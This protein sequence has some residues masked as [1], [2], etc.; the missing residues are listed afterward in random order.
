VNTEQKLK[1]E[2][3]TVITDNLLI[4]NVGV[5]GLCLETVSTFLLPNGSVDAFWP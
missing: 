2:V 5:G 1:W 3:S 4:Q